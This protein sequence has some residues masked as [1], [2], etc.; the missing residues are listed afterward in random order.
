MASNFPLIHKKINH[1][2]ARCRSP[3]VF[4]LL[5]LYEDLHGTFL[6]IMLLIY[7]FMCLLLEFF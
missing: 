6:L 5:C 3:H 2:T 4:L 1:S 7:M